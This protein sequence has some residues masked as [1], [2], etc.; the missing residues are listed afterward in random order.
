VST[1]ER[2]VACHCSMTAGA[3]RGVIPGDESLARTKAS[4][5]KAPTPAQ[6]GFESELFWSNLKIQKDRER[7][8]DPSVYD[9][10]LKQF[11]TIS[12]IHFA[13]VCIPFWVPCQFH[14]FFVS[15]LQVTALPQA[16]MC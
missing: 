9:F 10:V 14:P 11:H 4:S 13:M 7:E 1:L 3:K 15:C 16:T 8:R 12:N 2:M 5:V 6:L